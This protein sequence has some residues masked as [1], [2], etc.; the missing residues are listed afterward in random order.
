MYKKKKENPFNYKGHS[1]C[2]CCVC[3]P[4]FYWSQENLQQSLRSLTF[5]KRT[6]QPPSLCHSMQNFRNQNVR[7]SEWT[8]KKKSVLSLHICQ[9]LTRLDEK[10][11]FHFNRFSL[12][13]SAK[14][15]HHDELIFHHFTCLP[16]AYGCIDFTHCCMVY[17]HSCPV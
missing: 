5:T 1:C 15:C 11:T 13:S 8:R 2:L 16:T 7:E 6:E 17:L 12:N 10:Y 3:S 14:V 9:I 4:G